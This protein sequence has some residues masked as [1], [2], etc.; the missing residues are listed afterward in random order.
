M[1]S[2]QVIPTNIQ[3]QTQQQVAPTQTKPAQTQNLTKSTH[4][5][6]AS[7]TTS[8]VS[9]A[10]SLGAFTSSNSSIEKVTNVGVV[11]PV[12]NSNSS[13][14]QANSSAK[15]LN[16]DSS[17][18]G[19]G[20][21]N[22]TKLDNQ[23]NAAHTVPQQQ[24]QQQQPL[25]SHNIDIKKMNQQNQFQQQINN[26]NRQQP[27][28]QQYDSNLL[29]QH[30]QNLIQQRDTNQQQN[31]NVNNQH[32]QQQHQQQ[33]QQHHHQQLNVNSNMNSQMKDSSSSQNLAQAGNASG[34]Q[35]LNISPQNINNKAN[36]NQASNAPLNQQQQQQQLLHQNS[37]NT[38]NN[39]GLNQAGLNQNVNAA[40]A[41]AVKNTMPPPPGVNFNPNNQ[42][43]MSLPFVCYDQQ[44]FP[45]FDTSQ[46]DGNNIIQ[47]YNHLG[48]GVPPGVTSAAPTAAPAAGAT[49]GAPPYSIADSKFARSEPTN[50]NSQLNA[51]VA[52][53]SQ[54]QQPQQQQPIN[55]IPGLSNFPYFFPNYYP[56][57][58]MSMPNG[59]QA[60]PQFQNKPP[61]N[62]NNNAAYDDQNK[63]YSN[64]NPQ[65]QIKTPG[66]NL[67][68][69]PE[70]ASYQKNVDKTNTG[71]HTPPPNYSNSALMNQQQHPNVSATSGAPPPPAQFAHAYMIGAPNNPL[72]HT[73]LQ[74]DNTRNNS[75]ASNMKTLQKN[76]SYPNPWN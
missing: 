48:L 57:M 19:V 4:Q 27:K 59:P 41:A 65:G 70:I 16:N 62:F 53:L 11:N 63:D 28:H 25:M 38:N 7:T 9:S 44:N 67:N 12:I 76:T 13:S 52:Q 1:V 21:A 6:S 14:V 69:V 54:Q 56:N 55:L 46:L 49:P 61:Y 30:Q 3:H 39:N 33:Q 58:F 64:Y 36:T 60:N 51:N 8:S 24:Q 66:S 32:Y 73:G 42:F 29:G 50:S 74:Q 15:L 72:V 18:V 40:V 47:M 10:S 43:L 26:L 2:P 68:N 45:Y 22:S 5:P 71:Y 35:L 23:T 20:T 31:A 75:G 17:I 37:T 34:A